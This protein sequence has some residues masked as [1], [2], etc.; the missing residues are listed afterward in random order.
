MAMQ[1][2]RVTAVETADAINAIEGV[3]VSEYARELSYRWA[4]GEL[5]DDDMLSAL[6]ESHK[7]LA[8]RV[9]RNG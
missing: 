6:L 8:E 1:Q 7:K 5:G 9:R 4:R 3:P 2:K